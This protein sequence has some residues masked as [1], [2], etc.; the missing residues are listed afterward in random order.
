MLREERHPV[1]VI[2]SYI[3]PLLGISEAFHPGDPLCLPHRLHSARVCLTAYCTST[4]HPISSHT[5]T[6]RFCEC[7]PILPGRQHQK[8]GTWKT[9]FLHVSVSSTIKFCLLQPL[10]SLLQSELKGFTSLIMFVLNCRN[11]PL[12]F[13]MPLCP[14]FFCIHTAAARD[15]FLKCRSDHITRLLK[16]LH[17][18]P[19]A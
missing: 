2:P 8:P 5:G 12:S 16:I 13:L 17:Y 19:L 7:C 18:A 11:S 1:D 14:L 3:F 6:P 15:I 4:F 10:N 9:C